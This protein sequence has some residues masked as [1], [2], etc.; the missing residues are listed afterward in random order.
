[1]NRS[2]TG[3]SGAAGI[4]VPLWKGGAFVT[5]YTH[6]YRAPSLEELYNNGPHLGSLTFEVGNENLK[7]ERSNGFDLSL[8]HQA[9]RVRAEGNFFYYRIGNFVFLAPTGDIEDGLIEAEFLQGRTRYLGGEANLDV[10]LHRFLWLNLGLDVVRAEL[11]E[12]VTTLSTG[13]VTPAGASL[14]RIPPLRGRVGFDLRWNGLSVRPEAVL[15]QSQERL[16]LTETRTPGFAVFNLK[17]S[18]TRAQMHALHVLSFEAFNL[19]DRL[20]R[21]HLSFIKDLAPEIGRGVRFGYTVRFF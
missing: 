10:G 3:F 19:G 4:H 12:A 14:P 17:A 7:A 6:S 9:P 18:Y 1:V 2:F 13:A 8:R 11:R 20:Y 16:F 5:N 15:A 21:N